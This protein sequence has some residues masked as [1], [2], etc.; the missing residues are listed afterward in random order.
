MRSASTNW[1]NYQFV[2]RT[3]TFSRQA[4]NPNS[5][6]SMENGIWCTSPMPFVVPR[7]R[8]QSQHRYSRVLRWSRSRSGSSMVETMS[9]KVSSRTA[10][11]KQKHEEMSL[12]K[13]KTLQ[14]TLIR[15]TEKK[16]APPQ[17]THTFYFLF[18]ATQWYIC[19]CVCVC[20]CVLGNIS[21][22]FLLEKSQQGKWRQWNSLIMPLSETRK[23][24]YFAAR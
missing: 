3:R 23:R 5:S 21:L 24:S 15:V 14:T 2:S 20:V 19:A 6:L 8:S 12:H 22:L 7:F 4:G 17:G 13:Q 9:S 11:G 10:Q 1:A 18:L 16:I